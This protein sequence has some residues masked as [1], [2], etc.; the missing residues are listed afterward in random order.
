MDGLVLPCQSMIV[1]GVDCIVLLLGLIPVNDMVVSLL[2]L[3][4]ES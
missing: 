1:R 2:F 3:E 4:E